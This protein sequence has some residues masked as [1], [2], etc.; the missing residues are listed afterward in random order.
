MPS[1]KKKVQ[2][3]VT[4]AVAYLRVSTDD[5]RLGT[6]AQLVA[7]QSYADTHKLTILATHEDH[8]ISGASPINQ[9]P[10]LAKAIHD[11]TSNRAHIIV[12][13]R[14]RI[15]RDTLVAI[16]VER[17]LPKPCQVLSADNTGNGSSPADDFMR[18]V[19]HGMAAY[20]REL[21]RERTTKAL[22]VL[23][24]QNKRVG[25]IPYGYKLAIGSTSDL[26]PNDEEQRT[27]ALARS[28]AALGLSQRAIQ[29]ELA[30]RGVTGRGGR[31]MSLSQVQRF[32]D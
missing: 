21:I 23:A 22:A 28:L 27:I 1:P 13:K 6:Q 30:S 24:A 12:A 3:E 29:R 4:T 16:Q 15:A 25:S 2:S 7:I 32:F 26:A 11:A 17:A 19:L 8:G 20:E 31:P 10:A 14:D 9:R 5:Q 18:S